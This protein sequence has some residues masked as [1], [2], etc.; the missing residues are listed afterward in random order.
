MHVTLAK[1]AVAVAAA[2]L[3]IGILAPLAVPTVAGAATGDNQC[4]RFKSSEKTFA[5]KMNLARK[6]IGLRTMKLDPEL[7]KVARVHSREMYRK[8]SLYHTSSSLLGWRVTRWR[9]L[10][11]NVG[12]G[13]SV[14]SLHTAFMNSPSHRAN[15]LHSSFRNVGVGVVARDGRIWVTVVF[16]TRLNPGTRLKM[17]RC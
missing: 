17:P 2:G 10:G 12:Y 5:R 14:D 6:T 4:Y 9:M 3:L 8:N 1:R 7:G 11:E 13:G 15:I 16:E